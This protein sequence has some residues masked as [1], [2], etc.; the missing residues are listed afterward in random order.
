MDLI[1]PFLWFPAF[2]QIFAIFH[3]RRRGL[4]GMN[5]MIRMTIGA[6]P[7]FR[8]NGQY[9]CSFPSAVVSPAF[10]Q[11]PSQG[12]NDVTGAFTKQ[13]VPMQTCGVRP[14]ASS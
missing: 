4:P 12:F 7:Q 8:D 11:T 1:L 5:F 14:A 6:S 9:L 10:H 3:Y 2:N 13:A